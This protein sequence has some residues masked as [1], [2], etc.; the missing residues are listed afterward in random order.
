MSLRNAC[1]PRSGS[2]K[3]RNLRP[4]QNGRFLNILQ[5]VSIGMSLYGFA[6]WMF[7]RKIEALKP[8]PKVVQTS[9][10]QASR[11]PN[12]DEEPVFSGLAHWIGQLE[13]H[14]LINGLL[15]TSLAA[16]VMGQVFV[17]PDQSGGW[18]NRA[19][20]PLGM[21]SLFLVAGLASVVSRQTL[22]EKR[23]DIV[24]RWLV[25]WSGWTFFALLAALLDAH[26]Q[27]PFVGVRTLIVGGLLTSGALL[28]TGI[29]GQRRG[30]ARY[31]W[32]RT[33]RPSPGTFPVPP[34]PNP[35]WYCLSGTE[36]DS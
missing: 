33:S 4:A 1:D 8:G 17:W 24:S 11:S 7:R 22:S 18:V 3:L 35:K 30:P 31:S 34:R 26:T 28:T 13:L 29:V 21:I 16:L 5:A 14:T 12:T 10:G 27:F 25:V 19:G 6:W 23:R 9:H 32:S 15:V 2:Q 36:Q 20:S